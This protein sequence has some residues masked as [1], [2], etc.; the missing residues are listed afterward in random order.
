MGIVGTSEGIEKALE[1]VEEISKPIEQA[2][3]IDCVLYPSFPG[4]NSQSPFRVHLLTQSQWHRA[5]H[6]RHFRSLRESPDFGTRR[7]LLQEMF[8][9]EVRTL[10]ELENPPHVILCAV[11][12]SDIRFLGVDSSGPDPNQ[13]QKNEI[14]LEARRAFQ[15]TLRE[16]WAGLKA[17]CM[18]ALPTE[19]VC[20]RTS[21][22]TGKILDR[23]TLAWN[24]SLALFHKAALKSWRLANVPEDSCF[25]GISSY[26]GV[27][28]T[29]PHA[30][31]S[32]AHVVTELGDGFIIGGDAVQSDS[33]KDGGEG[34]H[35]AENRARE[36]LSQAIAVVKKKTGVIP[37]RITVHKTT[38]YFD[39]ERRGFEGAVSGVGEYAFTTVTRRGIFCMRP[40]RKPIVRGTAI[41]F[42]EKLGLIST[43]GYVPFLRG[44]YGNR[45]LEPLEITE[46]WGSLSFQQVV[47]DI[48]RLT[49]LDLNSANFCSEF[50]IT[51]AHSQKVAD[52]LRALGRRELSADDR[53]YI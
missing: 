44:S 11:S 3:N 12:E 4:L 31:R 25:V 20:D 48:V 2:D 7:W 26:R 52:V 23:A 32:F 28:E 47:V 34:T 16:F 22:N 43:A 1:L 29:S 41:P 40:G 18:G 36:L 14:P 50:P 21:S 27:R 30:L 49:K 35:L 42:D 33:G 51:L 8:G 5:L 38:S 53:Y 19:I 46:N 9:A 17:E 15:K 6:K 13:W 10:S 39:A 37:R 24:L 45:L